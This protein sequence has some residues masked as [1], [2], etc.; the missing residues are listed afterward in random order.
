MR[1]SDWLE[2]LHHWAIT[3]RQPRLTA[4][5][6]K[7]YSQDLRNFARW[8][9]TA[10]GQPFL[11]ALLRHEDAEAWKQHEL[12]RG[13]RPSSINR[14][15]AALRFLAEWLKKTGQTEDR[16]LDKLKQVPREE[17]ESYRWLELTEIVRLYRAIR[18]VPGWSDRRRVMTEALLRIM[19]E[20]GLRVDETANLRLDDLSLTPLDQAHLTVRAGRG[21]HSRRVP[22]GQDLQQSLTA[23]LALRKGSTPWL[24][25]GSRASRLG[26]SAIGN[27]VRVLA[28]TAG[29]QA[30]TCQTL[31]V[32]CGHMLYL[33]T[34]NLWIV[35]ALMGHFSAD[36]QP[37]PSGCAN[38]VYRPGQELE[39]PDLDAYLCE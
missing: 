22:F 39:M 6:L 18:T 37:L 20:A 35:A 26:H 7:D 16:L 27:S 5:T 19:L 2:Q 24:F 21:G 28:K 17:V 1:L 29:I 4:K 14:A 23:W 30:V 3:E 33:K 12:A 9:D 10:R 13:R 8:V 36:G 15:L 11:P 38:Y 34:K 31:R 25:P 32:T